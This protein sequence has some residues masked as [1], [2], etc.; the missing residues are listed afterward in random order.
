MLTLMF[1]DVQVHGGVHMWVHIY[2]YIYIDICTI[3]CVLSLSLLEDTLLGVGL[4][5]TP[6]TKPPPLEEVPF[7]ETKQDDH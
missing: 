3:I 2:I 6:K 4:K 1:E 5:E 7:A